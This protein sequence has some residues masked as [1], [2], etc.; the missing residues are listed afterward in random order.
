MSGQNWKNWFPH[1][2]FRT[3][4]EDTLCKIVDAFERVPVVI[5]RAPCGSG[6]S[7]IALAIARF[8]RKAYIATVEKSLQDQIY[9]DFSAHLALLK[10]KNNYTCAKFRDDDGRKISCGEAP[11]GLNLPSKKDISKECEGEGICPYITARSEAIKCAP[12]TLMN[13][14]NMLLFSLQ[15]IPTREIAIYD[16]AHRLVEQLDKFA[17]IPFTPKVFQPAKR[18]LSADEEN[19]IENGFPDMAAVETFCKDLI[20]RMEKLLKRGPIGDKEEME[21]VKLQS[22]VDKMNSL[23]QHIY[24]ELP[25]V[26]KKEARGSIIAPLFVYHVAPIAF[27]PGKRTLLMSAT[28]PDAKK[29]ASSLGIT[30]YEFIDVPSTFPPE[31]NPIIYIPVGSMSYTKQEAT[32]PLM[33]KYIDAILT[34]HKNDKGIIQTYNYAIAEKLKK[35]LGS[36][37]RYL[38]HIR[39]SD[40]NHLLLE[41][42]ESKEPTVLIGPGFKEG[43]DLKDDLARFSIIAKMP[44][45]DMKDPIIATRKERD[46]ES[47]DI[48]TLTTLFQMLGRVIRSNKD[49]AVQYILDTYFIFLYRKYKHMFPKEYRDAILISG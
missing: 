12:L 5:V 41:H 1:S 16:E 29:L 2:E 9:K 49:H 33:V 36:N 43:V 8:Y 20:P 38:F 47:Y 17:E 35:A 25:F 7:P 42:F 11:C 4:Q 24:E 39:D 44:C 48:L 32:M 27:R 45:A 40:K 26:I 10:G 31:N 21:F 22:Q 37:P 14:S 18:L 13:Y 34:K 6:K 46:P 3:H 15:G 19:L 28:I 23:L 30:E